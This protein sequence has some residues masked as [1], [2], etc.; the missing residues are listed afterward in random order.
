MIRAEGVTKIFG[1]DPASALE[2][3]EQGRSKDDIRAET[4]HTVG[5]NNVSFSLEP[6]EF[7]VIMGLSGSGKSTLLRCINRLIEPT[8]GRIYLQTEDEG[9]VDITGLDPFALRQLRKI[10]MS[11]VF[12]RFSLFPHRTILD[13]V[14]YGLEIQRRQRKRAKEIGEEMIGLVGLS[15]Y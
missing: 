6:G 12:Q 11:M 13:N 8:A 4:G 7:F 2:L 5:V 3:L 9:E 10:R 1:P 15:G 14:T